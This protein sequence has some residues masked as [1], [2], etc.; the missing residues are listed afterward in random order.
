ML[1]REMAVKC[2]NPSTFVTGRELLF[3]HLLKSCIKNHKF[4][5]ISE[6]SW[7]PSFAQMLPIENDDYD[8]I[9][10]CNGINFNVIHKSNVTLI[11]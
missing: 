11:K 3:K 4:T 6:T 2:A 8:S 1:T 10:L 9:S 5:C 7:D